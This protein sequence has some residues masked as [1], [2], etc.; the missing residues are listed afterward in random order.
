[1]NAMTVSVYVLRQSSLHDVSEYD[2]ELL[3]Q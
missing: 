3:K 2:A 1:M